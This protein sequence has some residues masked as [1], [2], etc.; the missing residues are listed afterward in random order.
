MLVALLF[1]KHLILVTPKFL[2]QVV[3]EMTLVF[4]LFIEILRPVNKLC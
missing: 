2:G 3:K 4:P 1:L